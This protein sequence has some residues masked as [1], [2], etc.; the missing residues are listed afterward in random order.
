MDKLTDQELFCRLKTGDE[1]AF[2]KLFLKYYAPLCVF[3]RQYLDDDKTEEVVQDMFVRIWGKRLDLEIETSV[4]QYFFRSVKN[5]CL[6]VIQ[7]EKIKQKYSQKILDDNRNE[8]DTSPYFL[9]VGLQRKI[10]ESINALPEKRRE[11][12]KLSREHGM[13]YKEIAGHLNI[14]VKTVE[15]Q[16]GIALKQLREMLKDYKDYFIGMVIFLTSA[17]RRL[18]GETEDKLS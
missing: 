17:G 16:M 4:K 13:K 11:I 15:A 12:F 1:P 2:R 3:A 18:K 7:H 5:Q 14:S 6:N 9:E 8:L 10:E